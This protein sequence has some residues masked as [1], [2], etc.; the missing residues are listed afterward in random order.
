MSTLPLSLTLQ[1]KGDELV[2]TTKLGIM[3]YKDFL[4]L[5]EEG[6]KVEVTYEPVH[7]DAS[8]A[9][10][11]KLHKCIRIIATETGHNFDEIKEIVKVKSGLYTHVDRL[12]S[13]GEL[14][15]EEISKVIQTVI[16]MGTDLG[17]N[18]GG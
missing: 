14:S 15:K 4:T 3:K 12:K 2:I 5:L 8:Y 6:A 9:Q 11:S 13:F 16:E 10:L 1:K 18:L 7:G 17:I